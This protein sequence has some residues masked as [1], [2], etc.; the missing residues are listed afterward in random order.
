MKEG[1]KEDGGDEGKLYSLLI[2]TNDLVLKKSLVHFVK[3]A[4]VSSNCELHN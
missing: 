1:T 2:K 3:L 4:N